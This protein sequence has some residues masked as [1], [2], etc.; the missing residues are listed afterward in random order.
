MAGSLTLSEMAANVEMSRGHI[1]KQ[2]AIIA[3][4]IDQ[5]HDALADEA[6]RILATMH[7]HLAFEIDMLAR[8]QANAGR[9][10]SRQT[11]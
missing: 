3:T 6:K 11:R 5:G 9:T 8:M 7:V 4:L 2:D 10:D 1:A